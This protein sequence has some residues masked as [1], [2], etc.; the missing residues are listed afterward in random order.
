MKNVLLLVHDDQG[1][2]ARLQTALDLTR[3]LNGHLTC[4]DVTQ[5]PMIVG[6]GYATFGDSLLI[7]DERER[8]E[9]NKAVVERR[10]GQEGVA[11]NWIDDAGTIETCILDAA[12]LADLIVLNRKL[13]SYPY[14]DMHHITSTLLMKA[15]KPVVAVSET[16]KQFAVDRVMI[17]WDGQGAVASTLRACIPLLNLAT[18]VHVFTV[19][20]GAQTTD[21][22]DAAQYLSRHDIHPTVRI[23]HDGLNPPDQLIAEEAERLAIDYVIMGAYSHGR[24]RET[25]GGVTKRMLAHSKLPLVLGH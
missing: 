25:F 15:G 1:Q 16:L 11:W 10:L 3:A 24:L 22:E 6:D 2:E 12:N 20:D 23:V 21:V 19:H 8:E 5:I 4:V 18:Y 9:N 17:A 7:A 13:D 14:P